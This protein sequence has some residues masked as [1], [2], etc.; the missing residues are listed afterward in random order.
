MSIIKRRAFKFNALINPINPQPTHDGYYS[1]PSLKNCLNVYHIHGRLDFTRFN[2]CKHRCA[3]PEFPS[4]WTT[5]EDILN[6]DKI[7]NDRCNACFSDN[8][9]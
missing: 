9:V 2:T 3:L 4:K 8:L 1:K 5:L 6:N 7:I